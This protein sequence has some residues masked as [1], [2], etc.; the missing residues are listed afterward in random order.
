[1]SF[2]KCLSNENEGFAFNSDT[3]LIKFT[4]TLHENSIKI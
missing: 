3:Y 4:E 1:M 2:M